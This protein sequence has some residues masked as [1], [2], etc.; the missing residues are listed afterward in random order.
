MMK[1]SW[2]GGWFMMKDNNSG[3]QLLTKLLPQLPDSVAGYL[4]DYFQT[5]PDW[6]LTSLKLMKAR[7]DHIFIR[8]G[9]P[10]DTIFLLAMGIVKAIDYRF[11]GNTYD[12]MWFHPV[13]DFGGMEVLLGQDTYQTTLSTVTPCSFLVI[14]RSLYEQWMNTDIRVLKM[15]ARIMGSFLLEEVKR[16]RI[17]L[18]MQG[19]DRLTYT[20]LH[21]YEHT[22]AKNGCII[23]LTQ[24]NLA[25][26]T[27]LSVKTISRALKELEQSGLISRSGNKILISET[28]YHTMQDY[29]REKYD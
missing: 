26:R 23:R 29:I 9:A 7:K 19:S 5:A 12:Y 6:L 18:F 25:D 11:Y 21:I 3:S 17:F 1:E 20:L 10:V 4:E 15:N 22:A 16:E 24:Q 13:T 8:E 27:G 28:G 14:P 2:F